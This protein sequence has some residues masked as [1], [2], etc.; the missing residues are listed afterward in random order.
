MSASAPEPQFKA[1]R[2][3]TGSGSRYHLS[4]RLH[5][6]RGLVCAD[7]WTNV[8][9]ISGRHKQE[10]LGT[11]F[12]PGSSQGPC[13]AYQ[14]SRTQQTPACHGWNNCLEARRRMRLG[15]S[16]GTVGGAHSEMSWG[17]RRAL[18]HLP[19]LS[20][21]GET[22]AQKERLPVMCPRAESVW[23]RTGPLPALIFS[24]TAL[25]MATCRVKKMP[26]PSHPKYE[27]KAYEWAAFN[28]QKSTA[29]T[30]YKWTN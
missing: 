22:E 30:L 1:P 24:S 9:T 26:P 4:Q 3:G 13:S 14:I 16:L 20:S 29:A 12:I 15:Q 28:V 8:P 10:C 25:C 27:A 5:Y 7:G 21:S 6:G 23:N 19:V 11:I 18:G 2:A 17:P